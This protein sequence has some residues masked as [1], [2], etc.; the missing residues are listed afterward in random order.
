META[1]AF[2][3]IQA[4]SNKEPNVHS[5]LRFVGESCLDGAHIELCNLNK[6]VMKYTYRLFVWAAALVLLLDGG[7]T[8]ARAANVAPVTAS[9]LHSSIPD[10]APAAT[11][12]PD[13]GNPFPSII[14]IATSVIGAHSVRT[15]DFDNDGDMDVVVADARQRPGA[16]V[17]EPRHEPTYLCAPCACHCGRQ[18]YGHPCRYRP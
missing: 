2:A 11:A 14:P 3:I 12:V 17:R 7:V 16:M 18:L 13:A 4:D 10:L 6:R 1:C 5:Q 8:A 9:S 15:A